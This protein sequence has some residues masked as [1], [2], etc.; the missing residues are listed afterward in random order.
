V[1]RRR[2]REVEPVTDR[3]LVLQGVRL[4]V[5]AAIPLIPLFTGNFDAALVPLALAYALV[6][7]TV[8][9][10]RRQLPRLDPTLVLWTVLVD[11]LV[12]AIAVSNT[13]GYRSPLLF[14]VFLLVVAAT[15]LVTYRTGL[16]LATWCAILLLLAHAA[17]EADLFGS[18]PQVSD[19]FAIVSAS[20]FLV[21]ALSAAAFSSVNERALRHSR[22]QLEWV[23][24]LDAELAR[25]RHSEE[26]MAVL[27][28]HVCG[29]LGFVRGVVLAGR[30]DEWSG[31]CDD[32]VV[33]SLIEIRSPATLPTLETLSSTSPLLVRTLDDEVL[34]AVLPSARNVVVVPVA[35]DDE[36]FGVVAAEWG[37]RDEAR[38]PVLTVHALSQAA[39]HT[40]SALRR[41]AL[42]DEVERLATRDSLTGIANRRL[43]DESLAREAA[44]A[45]RL[46]TPL[47][48]V[49]FDVDH[50]KQI[51]DTFGHVTG[52]ALLREIA[53]SIVSCTKSFDVAARYGGDEFML[54]LPGC[55][56]ADAVG[57][58][59]RVRAEIGRRVQAV[60][61]T[62]SAGLATMPDNADD[63]ERLVSA[64]DGALYEA[65]RSGR[66]RV[67]AS[68]RAASAPSAVVRLS[69]APL[70]RGA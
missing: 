34:D 2:P 39:S 68:T 16:G 8:E 57:V 28:R 58:A 18:K 7:A 21:F 63:A 25:A 44:R 46:Q 36:R 6:V 12:L 49:V 5:A 17:G 4:A 27:V 20:T 42:L 67:V 26:L 52:D 56:D 61:V 54:L 14:L 10:T 66:D 69:E 29:R 51:N 70:A 23:V 38:I 60:A 22:A 45:E 32:G 50:F 30:D 64:A 31:V 9:V 35:A 40:G 65:K 55:G 37:G 3:L 24:D 43:F 59:E 48:L 11:G 41:A 15:L 13:G 53:E 1:T 33:E 47:S 19:R 62:V